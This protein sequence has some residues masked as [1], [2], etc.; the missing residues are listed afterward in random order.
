MKS[1]VPVAVFTVAGISL[2]LT[3]TMNVFAIEPP[4]CEYYNRGKSYR[5]PCRVLLEAGSGG[6]RVALIQNLENGETYDRGWVQ[7]SRA[8]CILKDTAE[9]PSPQICAVGKRFYVRY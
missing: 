4:Q 8:G 2:N 9:Y 5:F 3:M 7:G 6:R 1:F